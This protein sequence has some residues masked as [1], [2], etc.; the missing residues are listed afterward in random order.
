MKFNEPNRIDADLVQDTSVVPTFVDAGDV[1]RVERLEGYVNRDSNGRVL[2]YKSVNGEWIPELRHAGNTPDDVTYADRDRIEAVFKGEDAGGTFLRQGEGK[3][4]RLMASEVVLSDS[5]YDGRV[6]PLAVSLHRDADDKFGVPTRGASE[7]LLSA[8][9][10]RVS[11]VASNKGRTPINPEDVNGKK[12]EFLAYETDAVTVARFDGEARQWSAG[13]VPMRGVDFDALATQLQYPDNVITGQVF[14]K[15]DGE[16]FTFR[17]DMHAK[18]F[19]RDLNALGLNS[20]SEADVLRMM[21][22]QAQGDERWI[23]DIENPHGNRYYMRFS[24]FPNGLGPKLATNEAMIMASGTPVGRYKETDMLKIITG[25]GVRRVLHGL[26]SAKHGSAYAE[27]I[28]GVKKLAGGAGYDEALFTAQDNALLE[29][30]SANYLFVDENG[31]VFAP[32]NERGETLPGIMGLTARE[33]LKYHGIRV[34][35][36]R[37]DAGRLSYDFEEVILCGT[38]MGY[39]GAKEIVKPNGGG[40]AFKNN[41]KRTVLDILRGDLE[42]IM[43]GEHPNGEFNKWMV[44][45][46]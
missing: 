10:P 37:I 41:E 36:D 45:M 19:V 12:L 46:G 11:F 16:I 28:R 6:S 2:A 15:R 20:I 17:P 34:Q 33:I 24:G 18:R 1:T 32:S 14:I 4:A 35:E 44:K 26:A 31:T 30:F 3:A 7:E 21:K 23:P 43:N 8:A 9:R 5:E 25:V 13:T 22:D 40:T 27:G 42:L 39:T 29:G 38:A